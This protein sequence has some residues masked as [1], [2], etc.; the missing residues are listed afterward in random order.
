MP[1]LFVKV[2][3]IGDPEPCSG[4]NGRVRD[5]D[6]GPFFHDL[7]PGIQHRPPPGLARAVTEVAAIAAKTFSYMVLTLKL[8]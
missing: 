8:F 5:G 6:R 2:I 3:V 1:V 4:I 7:F